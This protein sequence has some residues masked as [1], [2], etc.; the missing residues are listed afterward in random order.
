M[1]IPKFDEIMIPALRELAKADVGT[2]EWKQI[3]AP[4]A[5]FF[6][7]TEE[8]QATEYESGNGRIFID[9]ISWALSYLSIIELIER[10]KRGY[11]RITDLGRVLA[12]DEQTFRKHTKEKIAEHEARKKAK[13]AAMGEEQQSTGLNSEI[14][15]DEALNQAAQNI[16]NNVYEDILDTVLSK[17]P[18]EFEKLVSLSNLHEVNF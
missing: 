11:C 15:P 3:E 16:R 9:R 14:T 18:Y 7:L 1:A 13:K 10:P 4:L 12:E 2:I 6:N 5:K 17:K 8:E